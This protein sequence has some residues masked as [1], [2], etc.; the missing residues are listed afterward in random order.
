MKYWNYEDFDKAMDKGYINIMMLNATIPTG[1]G[2][3]GDSGTAPKSMSFFDFGKQ[4][5]GM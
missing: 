3:A 5:A 1:E 2:K 4:L